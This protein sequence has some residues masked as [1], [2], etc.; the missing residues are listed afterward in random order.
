M[1]DLNRFAS[2]TQAGELLAGCLSAYARCKDAIVLALPRG[3]VPVASVIAKILELP[4]DIVLVRKLGLPGHEEFAM[5][6]I[7]SGGARFL[8]DDV[9]EYYRISERVI[10]SVTQRELLELERREKLY[11]AGREAP[12]LQDRIL[13]LVDDGLATGS[14]MKVAVLA[15]QKA[16]PARVIIAVP[17]AATESLEKLRPDV[18]EIVCLKEPDLF[19]AVGAWYENFGQTSDEEVIRLLDDA[20]G[21]TKQREQETQSQASLQCSGS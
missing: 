3:G 9:V 2:R 14:T 19:F 21:D 10:E 5:G 1:S 4:L 11:R 15:V 8:Q 6:A 13:I 12:Q 16:H 18:D 20:E 17:V 7:A